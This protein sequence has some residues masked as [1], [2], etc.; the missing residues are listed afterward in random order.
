M[1]WCQSFRTRLSANTLNVLMIIKIAMILLII[2]A[3]FFPK[4]HVS[5]NQN[6]MDWMQISWSDL[7]SSFGAPW[8]A[9]CFLFT[10]G[11][12]QQTINFGDEIKSPWKNDSKKYLWWNIISDCFISFS[13]LSCYKIIGFEELK[14]A[15][16]FASIVASKLLV[17]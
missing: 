5:S 15:K 17:Q 16:G 2:S 12:Y 9:F 11:G 4:I 13:C 14:T 3:L 1:L 10:Y 8:F 6:Y 7:I